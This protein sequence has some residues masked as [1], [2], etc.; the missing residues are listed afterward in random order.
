MIIEPDIAP[1]YVCCDDSISAALKKIDAN[2]E[3]F[4]FCVDDAGVL[5]GVLTDGDIRRWL[6]KQENV[7]LS[8]KI[9]EIANREF[10]SAFFGDKRENISRLFSDQIKFVPLLDD[11]RRLVGFARQREILEALQIGPYLINDES[12]VFIIAEIGINHNGSV[13][14]ARKL[15]EA[16]KD[17]GADCAKFQMRNMKALYRNTADGSVI[18]E[19]LGAQYTLNLLSRFELPTTIMLE[20]FDYA[21]EI[22]L[23][24]LC[25]PWEEESVKIL[26]EYGM[27]AYKVASADLT[28]HPL[29]TI[30]A[31]TYKPLIV[32][33]GMSEEEEIK[34]T[35]KLLQDIGSKY[36][37]LH[38]NSTYPV[39]FKDVNL[40]YIPRLKKIGQ[41]PVGYSGHE[42]GI[43]VA[44]A[45]VAKGAKVIEKHITLD[46]SLEGSDHKVSLLPDE[47]KALVQGIRQVE[48]SLGTAHKRCMTQGEIMNR[49]NLAKSLV[50]NR[51]LKTGEVIDETMIDVKSPGRG[52][53]PNRK[54]ELTG[55]VAVRDFSKG[56]FFFP[57]D[58][59]T[60][61]VQAREYRF[62][63]PWGLT[64]RWHDFKR[65]MAQSNPD[66][67]EFHLSFKD[68]DEDYLTL[69]E[70]LYD[71]DL[72]VHSPDT[73]EGDHLLDLANPEKEY[74]DRS[75]R[76]LQRVIDLT[77][78]LKPFFQRADRPVIIASLSGF[79]SNGFLQEGWIKERYDILAE[80]LNTL[81]TLGVE[82]IGQTLPPFPW[83]FG[84][85]LYLN[86]FVRPHDTAQFC[87]KQ[88]LRLFQDIA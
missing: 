8:R 57:S 87:E 42:R 73:F 34:S 21:R 24:P 67:L 44:V 72:K 54:T 69:F 51:D 31:Q 61:R 82:I 65:I 53:Q 25:T 62:S 23:V 12:S 19:D 68:M 75:I 71:L 36:C 88:D 63:R 84:G 22:G 30:L 9:G 49:A 16:A 74:R 14:R 32:S 58:L 13:D 48:E 18:N 38:C 40:N 4:I 39:P 59:E 86:L 60:T 35:V 43:N 46:R 83:Y 26:E 64:V 78:K 27:P 3:G 20:L 17:A 33:T 7:N 55:R 81:D 47:F 28:D 6:L 1:Y 70:C 2:N 52:L 77:H 50:V 11:R 45:A 79:T 85:Q 41:C 76:E 29:L 66:F 15:I 37:L 10:V 56:D 5:E 80:S